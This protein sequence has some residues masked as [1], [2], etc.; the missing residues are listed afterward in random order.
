MKKI[1]IESM[2]SHYDIRVPS[3]SF[4]KELALQVTPKIRLLIQD[5]E[6]R[7]NFHKTICIHI[8]P[9]DYLNPTF[10]NQ[11]NYIKAYIFAY[12]T[13]LILCEITIYWYDQ[14]DIQIYPWEDMP[15]N[16]KFDLLIS[17]CQLEKLNKIIPMI[18]H[19][20]VKAKDS[21]L[22]FDYQ[23]FYGGQYLN[24]YFNEK[25][26]PEELMLIKRS[27]TEFIAEWNCSHSVKLQYF[28]IVKNTGMMIKIEI[29]FGGC[30][31][32]AIERLIRQIQFSKVKKIVFK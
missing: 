9:K 20:V 8:E 17:D 5:E 4:E 6:I 18:Y 2:P 32:D 15:T 25:I 10:K 27:I 30:T 7:E 16:I 3:N 1:T 13:A 24:I 31:K 12:S 23:I 14:K 22:H 29:D 21:G 28:E 11:K 19:P 26:T